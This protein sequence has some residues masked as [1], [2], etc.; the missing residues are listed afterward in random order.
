MESEKSEPNQYAIDQSYF[1]L[2]NKFR[3]YLLII[4]NITVGILSL[5]IYPLDRFENHQILISLTLLVCAM[6]TFYYLTSISIIDNRI[7][8]ILLILLLVNTSVAAIIVNAPFYH[9]AT[10]LIFYMSLF[11]IR[12]GLGDVISSNFMEIMISLTY[13]SS[14]FFWYFKSESS[15]NSYVL[16]LILIQV[17]L[18]TVI[19]VRVVLTKIY[20]LTVLPFIYNFFL[21]P[22]ITNTTGDVDDSNWIVDHLADIHLL[23]YAVL[24]IVFLIQILKTRD[25]SSYY[26]FF[27]T[28]TIILPS[29]YIISK[30]TDYEFSNYE[31][32]SLELTITPFSLLFITVMVGLFLTINEDLAKNEKIRLLPL[33][34]TSVTM[35][36]TL[37]KVFSESDLV[38]VDHGFLVIAAL[39]P[40][41]IHF[42]FAQNDLTTPYQAAVLIMISLMQVG[43]VQSIHNLSLLIFFIIS[44]VLITKYKENTNLHYTLLISIGVLISVNGLFAQWTR[45]LAADLFILVAISLTLITVPL[46]TRNKNTPYLYFATF[47]VP[48]FFMSLYPNRG[49]IFSVQSID[50]D[51][52]DIGL[53]AFA[54]LYLLISFYNSNESQFEFYTYVYQGLI[55]ALIVFVDFISQPNFF[56]IAVLICVPSVQILV[57]TKQ[58]LHQNI[59]Y[60]QVITV[61]LYQFVE[62]KYIETSLVNF[63]LTTLVYLLYI[64]TSLLASI[65]SNDIQSQIA[66]ALSNLG[67]IA[68]Y[69]FLTI[70]DQSD[71]TIPHFLAIGAITV[72]LTLSAFK[73]SDY[74]LQSITIITQSAGIWLLH[75]FDNYTIFELKSS[76]LNNSIFHFHATEI[77]TSTTVLL[78]IYSSLLI[79]LDYIND[80][81]REIITPSMISLIVAISIFGESSLFSNSQPYVILGF[82]LVGKLAIN[83]IKNIKIELWNY[84]L[85]IPFFIIMKLNED[86]SY[87][88]INDETIY[89]VSLI[90]L[91]VTLL[92]INLNRNKTSNEQILVFVILSVFI[93]VILESESNAIIQLEF[94][95]TSILMAFALF[96]NSDRR[97]ELTTLLFMQTIVFLGLLSANIDSFVDTTFTDT[98][99]YIVITNIAY[100]IYAG[101]LLYISLSMEKEDWYKVLLNFLLLV[102]GSSYVLT[103]EVHPIIIAA[104]ILLFTLPLLM[105]NI[106][107][108]RTNLPLI[109]SFSLLILAYREYT[110]DLNEYTLVFDFIFFTIWSNLIL[111][112]WYRRGISNQLISTISAIFITG[113]GYAG[114]HLMGYMSNFEPLFLFIPLIEAV[115][116]NFIYNSRSTAISQNDVYKILFSSIVSILLISISIRDLLEGNE[117]VI[118][119]L[120]IDWFLFIPIFVQTIIY[121]RPIIDQYYQDVNKYKDGDRSVLSIMGLFTLSALLIGAENM[122]SAKL[123]ALSIVFWLFA[124]TVVRPVLSWTASIFSIF[125]FGFILAQFG[126]GTGGFTEYFLALAFFGV[127]MTGLGLVND[128]KYKGEPFTASLMISG[129]VLTAVAVIM[130]LIIQEPFPGVDEE[131]GL[132]IINFIPNVVW[133]IQGLAL[134]VISINLSKDYLRRLALSILIVDIL[135]TG[136]NIVLEGDNPLIRIVGAIVLGGVLILIFYLFTKEGEEMIEVKAK[137]T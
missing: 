64:T 92:S 137:S 65:K 134:F 37:T 42:R 102:A 123:L 129:S 1:D 116:I 88:T 86:Q 113:G 98:I 7:T 111:F 108:V 9:V 21:I 131:T 54:V 47:I 97:R 70:T 117:L 2:L 66:T 51:L 130:P 57:K 31:I 119:R 48:W 109:Q 3:D 50:F 95:L 87:L 74:N 8:I 49:N 58:F 90:F 11:I 68:S 128:Y 60:S 126:D 99:K 115:I 112:M 127:I 24:V 28:H 33:F 77:I 133:A 52:L 82:I 135:K 44:V 104:S 46:L 53:L 36:F 79:Y 73:V 17:L 118:Y 20:Q 96:L 76:I 63:N 114:L 29:I 75:I 83:N 26:Y 56:V 78:I 80:N 14:L 5:F 136:F 39:I 62:Q 122:F 6:V 103:V 132:R 15:S 4:I 16:E 125:T 61:L 69:G 121:A 32:S 43:F 71:I 25:E 45:Y 19:F 27:T 34:A 67:L 105:Q 81:L 106:E 89:V 94:Y 35:F 18:A 40:F 12:K 100:L 84:F 110:V 55:I 72:L 38:F 93:L 107:H 41:I 23:I 91:L 101:L 22:I 120:I 59:I 13:A 30:I 124:G 85:I 10:I